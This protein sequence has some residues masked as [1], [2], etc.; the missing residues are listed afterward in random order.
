VSPESKED[1]PVS[2]MDSRAIVR[3]LVKEL[4]H[5]YANNDEL[6]KRMQKI[7]RPGK[8]KDEDDDDPE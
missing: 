7:L 1:S 3:Q 8:Y 4:M 2:G 6:R 5:A